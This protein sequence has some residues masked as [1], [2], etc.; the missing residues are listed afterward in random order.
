[1]SDLTSI[2]D[3]LVCEECGRTDFETRGKLNQH[4]NGHRAAERNAA[5]QAA[6]AGDPAQPKSPRRGS[7]K[8]PSFDKRVAA[9]IG[10]IGGGVYLGGQAVHSQ[11]LMRDGALLIDIA[12]EM[13]VA[14]AEVATESEVMRRLGE[15]LAGG[16]AWGSFALVVM[17]LGMGIAS[18]HGW[19]P[20]AP[21]QPGASANGNGAMP[22][23][24]D[25]LAA[26]GISEEQ[27]M[28]MAQAMFS[29]NGAVKEP[30]RPEEGPL[31]GEAVAGTAA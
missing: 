10:S 12:P 1:M 15:L 7:A 8:S 9:G 27:A 23:P 2:D 31:T 3:E 13:G 17:K 16:S 5:K 22:N 20:G 6:A 29:G 19:M 24:A 25:L 30:L 26:M 4:I 21:A 18:N 14:W 28:A 11:A